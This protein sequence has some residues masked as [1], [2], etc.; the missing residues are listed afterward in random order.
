M[1]KDF[2][3]FVIEH[4][5]DDL[6]VDDAL[7]E[8]GGA[9]QKFLNIEDGADFPANFIENQERLR[10]GSDLLKKAR[11]FNCHDKAASEQSDDSLLVFGE[12]IRV[13]AL[14]V[15]DADGFSAEEE[16]NGEF[17]LHAFDG[18][19]VARILRNVADA[20]G[21]AGRDGSAGDSL[22][23]GDTQIFGEA[24]WI[25]DSEAMGKIGACFIQQQNAE[26]FV[27]D[28]PLD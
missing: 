26:K 6:V 9:A 14:D 7:D 23:H 12:V 27:V 5:A 4:D 17:G 21:L 22:P 11:I 8:F 10:L 16:R 15:Q 28:M 1:T 2:L 25:A 18:I 24:R 20:D 13:A 19:D 3:L